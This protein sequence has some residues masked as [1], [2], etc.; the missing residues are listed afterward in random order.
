MNARFRAP[1]E[2]RLPGRSKALRSL[3]WGGMAAV[4]AP[5]LI[6]SWGAC[7]QGAVG[8]AQLSGCVGL[9]AAMVFF[10]LKLWNV[11]VLRFDTSAKSLVLTAV[12]VALL[13]GNAIERRLECAVLANDT[14]IAAMTLFSLGLKRV[15]RAVL[16][17][18]SRGWQRGRQHVTA[19]SLRGMAGMWTFARP[20]WILAAR[21]CTPRAPPA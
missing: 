17:A 7:L 2:Y 3:L 21:L 19:L 6:A 12:A 13:H 11:E 15:R 9:S 5:A 16:A 20:R 14:P 18:A 8:A 10:G 1:L 4:H